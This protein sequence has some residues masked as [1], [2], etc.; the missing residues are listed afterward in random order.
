VRRAGALAGLA[1]AFFSTATAADE[2]RRFLAETS[3]YSLTGDT[4][5]VQGA[6][7]WAQNGVAADEGLRL[8]VAAAASTW[9]DRDGRSVP[10]AI[11]E[12][13]LG[14]RTRVAPE[15]RLGLQL[16]L[17]VRTEW[18]ELPCGCV[19]GLTDYGALIAAEALWTP[20]P[21]FFA[22]LDL[23][24]TAIDSR[25]SATLTTGWTTPLGVKIGPQLG[26][27]RSNDGTAARAGIALT[28]IELFGGEVAL[29]GGVGRSDQG[30]SGL[31]LSVYLARPF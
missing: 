24:A 1:L 8:R 12:F 26:L 30:R 28:G 9:R 29:A 27:E 15:L 18:L 20:A 7:V 16:G 17:Q 19:V 3:F 14:A 23:R 4:L 25:L 5:Y 22:A 6:L 11:E 13:S 2:P 10:K 21:G 31:Y